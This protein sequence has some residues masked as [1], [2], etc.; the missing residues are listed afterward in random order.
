MYWVTLLVG[1]GSLV[2]GLLVGYA[3]GAH[4]AAGTHQAAHQVATSS[5]TALLP[6]PSRSNGLDPVVTDFLSVDRTWDDV[7]DSKPSIDMEALY[8]EMASLSDKRVAQGRIVAK[9]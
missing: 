5:A 8:R 7:G 9:A 4:Q 2:A 3:A 1:I 6:S